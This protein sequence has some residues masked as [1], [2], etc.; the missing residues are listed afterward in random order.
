[1]K[2]SREAVGIEVSHCFLFGQVLEDQ[3]LMCL[4]CLVAKLIMYGSL[5]LAQPVLLLR[6]EIYSRWL[7]N[8]SIGLTQIVH[9]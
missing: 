7:D 2:E 3:Q 6:A 4:T 5:Y 9:S 1:M 8:A